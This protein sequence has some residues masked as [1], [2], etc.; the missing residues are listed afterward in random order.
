MAN[1]LNWFGWIY[2]TRYLVQD[3]RKSRGK[4]GKVALRSDMQHKH[5]H[6]QGLRGGDLRVRARL[7]EQ[8]NE[9]KHEALNSSNK[10]GQQNSHTAC[11]YKEEKD[12]ISSNPQVVLRGQAA[13]VMRGV[14]GFEAV[15][16]SVG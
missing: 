15:D 3:S 11:K 12:G 6:L 7:T 13:I 1:G 10:R 16:A 5:A 14:R 8:M 4:V 2:K 9:L